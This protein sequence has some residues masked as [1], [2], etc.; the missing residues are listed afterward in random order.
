MQHAE[1]V[2]VNIAFGDL[3]GLDGGDHL[4]DLRLIVGGHDHVVARL[5]GQHGGAAVLRV[6]FDGI[7]REIVRHDDAGEAERVAQ[8]RVD[9]RRKGRG[10]RAVHALDDVV[11]HEH[12]RRARGDAGFKGDEVGLF[13]RSVRARV[14]RDARVRVGVVAVAGEVL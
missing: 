5:N 4:R 3:A 13:K 10:I 14:E 7:H 1:N 6:G 12:E 11:A 8:Q 2:R 9:L